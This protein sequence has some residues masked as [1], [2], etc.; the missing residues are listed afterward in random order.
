MTAW[1]YQKHMKLHEIEELQSFLDGLDILKNIKKNSEYWIF[2][3]N[4]LGRYIIDVSES[5]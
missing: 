4:R 5:V 3:S 1:I 2:Y